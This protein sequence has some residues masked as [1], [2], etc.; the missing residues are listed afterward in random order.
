MS[1]GDREP[2]LWGRRSECHSLQQLLAG[3][4]AGRSEVLV[5][6]GEAGIGKTAL[7]EY[8]ASCASGCRN[9]RATGVES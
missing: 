6:R 5:L 8:L 9:A 1:R 3:V 7:L 2:G 4:R